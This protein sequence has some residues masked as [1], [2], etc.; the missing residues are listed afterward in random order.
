MVSISSNLSNNAL[1]GKKL[2]DREEFLEMVNGII[3]GIEKVTL[4]QVFL[5][6]IERFA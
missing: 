2:V 5:A 6:W 1:I 4:E 3:D